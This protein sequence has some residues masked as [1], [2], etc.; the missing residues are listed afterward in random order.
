MAPAVPYVASSAR[1]K[2]ARPAPRAVTSVPSTS[3]RKSR[4]SGR[5]TAQA[6]DRR[7]KR[8]DHR[9]DL[10]RGRPSPEGEA[11]RA[12]ELVSRTADGTQDVR[13]LAAGH[14]ARRAGRGGNATQ[15]EL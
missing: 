11:Q 6:L 12:L 9:V 10:R 15:V 7:G 2:A 14:V 1:P 3:N 5:E 13:R 4:T 8:V